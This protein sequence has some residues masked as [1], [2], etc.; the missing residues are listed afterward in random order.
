MP[1]GKPA[2]ATLA[3]GLAGLWANSPASA[4]S[5]SYYDTTSTGVQGTGG[6]SVLATPGSYGY[7]NSYSGGVGSTTIGGTSYGFYDDYVFQIT[8]A[9]ADSVS[10]TI[11]LGG[12]QAI[13]NLDAR[14]YSVTAGNSP[15]PVLG[16]P[17]GTVVEST[18]ETG[19]CFG[20][21]CSEAVIPPTMLDPGT[22]VLEIRGTVAPT[23]GAYSG[24]LNLASG[25]VN[26]NTT[27]PL[28]AALPLMV[29]G[30]AGMGL[31]GR[32]RKRVPGPRA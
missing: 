24:V 17:A 27:V 22:Y 12:S 5:L 21:T 19:S 9:T 31:W 8:G 23:S 25:D 18:D 30:L 10:S 32:R 29:S 26:S 4:L 11:S 3:L 13:N 28:P 2:I 14:I 6:S 15:L 1:L 20:V 16:T 7:S